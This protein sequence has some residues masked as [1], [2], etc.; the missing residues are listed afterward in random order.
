MDRRT[1]LGDVG[2][3]VVAAGLTGALAHANRAAGKDSVNDKIVVAMIGVKGRGNALLNTFAALPEV[4]LKYVCDL[5]D[6]V[7]AQRTTEVASKLG[8]R[9]EAVKD[10]RR[11]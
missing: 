3:K 11:A 7:L 9:P 5:D 6:N 1:F 2:S 10:F 4:E 8:R